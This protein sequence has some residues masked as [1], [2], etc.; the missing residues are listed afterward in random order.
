MQDS[1]R[2]LFVRMLPRKPSSGSLT[3]NSGGLSKHGVG[4]STWSSLK[5]KVGIVSD[6]PKSRVHGK[7]PALS[8][9]RVSH[10]L[11]VVEKKKYQKMSGADLLASESPKTPESNVAKDCLSAKYAL[12]NNKEQ[13]RMKLALMFRYVMRWVSWWEQLTADKFQA[14]GAIRRMQSRQLSRT[15][16]RW[17]AWY[18][19]LMRQKYKL[20]GAFRRMLR[21]ALSRVWEAW[22]AALAESRRQVRQTCPKSL[23]SMAPILTHRS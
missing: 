1:H 10:D 8:S 4:L 2:L 13:R 18:E 3:S 20:A 19:E 7:S 22:K 5:K 17:E 12:W 16:E 21:R 11:T 15:W 6:G 23:L 14:S 9:W